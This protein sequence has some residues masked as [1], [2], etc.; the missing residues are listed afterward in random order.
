MEYVKLGRSDLEVS[1]IGVGC[2]QLGG[3]DWG[4]FGLDEAVKGVRR[5]VELGVNFFDTADVYGLGQSEEVL[6][7][8]LGDF[9]RQ[10]VIA[11]KFGVNW[12]YKDGVQRAET[13]KDCSPRRVVEALEA[14]LRR[15][16]LDCIPLY[17]IHWPDPDTALEDTLAA[18]LKC[19][20]AGK[21]R[22]IGC[23]NFSVNTLIE[24]E[25]VG[26]IIA[27]LQ[28][29][30][31]LLERDAETKQLAFCRQSS[32]I[33]VIAYGALGQG[34]LTG[35]YGANDRF[36][37]SDRRSRLKLFQ[38][39][40]LETNLGVVERVRKVA[41][42]Y[43]KLPAQVAIRWVLEQPGVTVALAGVK[44]AKQS[45]E[46]FCA[47]GWQIATEDISYLSHGDAS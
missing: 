2:E 15:L 17:Q 13:F 32:N 19:C 36:P 29:P 5:A 23:S 9:R 46:N 11:T 45:E 30:Y 40:N 31:S 38:K 22:Y 26:E 4:R 14:S 28:I 6:S 37:S 1:R 12:R 18:L 3:A 34:L 47:L 44:S 39:N 33:G 16:K 42:R 25:E 27:S 35:K 8:A 21:V 10:A 41:R 43:S 24:T 7:K 20:D